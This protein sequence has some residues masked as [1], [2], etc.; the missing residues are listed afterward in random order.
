[1]TQYETQQPIWAWVVL[2]GGGLFLFSAFPGIFFML[3]IPFWKP[4]E[5][6]LFSILFMTIGL[7]VLVGTIWGMVRSF[8]ALREYQQI[9]KQRESTFIQETHPTTMKSATSKKPIWPW[10]IIAIGGIPLVGMGPGIL[11]LPIMPLFLAGMSTDSGTTPDYVPLLIIFIGY[12]L[13]IGY[14]ILLIIAIKA[15]RRSNK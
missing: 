4:D 3:L 2:I 5:F 10:I 8:K 15:L 9:K 7:L 1:M 11:M 14:I 12:G 6:N 13:M